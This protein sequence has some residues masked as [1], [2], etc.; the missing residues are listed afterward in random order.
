[1][2]VAE[3]LRERRVPVDLHVMVDERAGRIVLVALVPDDLGQVLDQ[4]AA[5]RDVQHLDAAAD[6][7]HRH[8]AVQRCLHQLELGAVT[9]LMDA[10]RLRMRLLAVVRRIEI[11]AAGEDDPVERVQRLFD[12][13]VARRYE[14]R[15]PT[16]FLDRT[17]V[18][19]RDQ[20]RLEIPVAPAGRRDVRG[21]ANDRS[22]Q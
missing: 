22:H 16:R 21:D 6:T 4:V 3:D 10:G 12:S 8:V 20:G 9:L 14:Q 17:H 15:P 5:A 2:P 7:E 18:V 19:V 13:L 11:G 1:M